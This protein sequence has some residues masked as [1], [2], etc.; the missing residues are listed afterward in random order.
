[1]SRWTRAKSKRLRVVRGGEEQAT[2]DSCKELRDGM[3]A[4][5]L[6]CIG[7]MSSG[8]FRLVELD[9]SEDG[10]RH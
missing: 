3:K 10:R 9:R 6:W 4:L 8:Q 5:E 1:M 7:W 2:S